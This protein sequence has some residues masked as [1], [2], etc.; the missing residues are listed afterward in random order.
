M[1]EIDNDDKSTVSDTDT[2]AYSCTMQISKPPNLIY[3]KHFYC[4]ATV[5]YKTYNLASRKI[6]KNNVQVTLNV[7]SMTTKT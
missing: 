6:P 7:V 1:N 2:I 4:L 3:C 5:R